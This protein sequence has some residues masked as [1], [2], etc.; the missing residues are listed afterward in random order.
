MDK[1][2]ITQDG[3]ELLAKMT[4]GETTAEFTKFCTSSA[5]YAEAELSNLTGLKDTCQTSEVTNVTI[6]E[7]HTVVLT[8]AI[9]NESLQEGYY[10]TA[11]GLFAQGAGEEEILY[12]VCK[13]TSPAYMPE[14]SGT[15]SGMSIKFSVKVGNSENLVVNVDNSTAATL[16]DLQELKDEVEAPVF[17]DYE[18]TEDPTLPEMETALG[19]IKS[20]TKLSKLMQYI[21]A[22]LMI[23]DK[24]EVDM[25]PYDQAIVELMD[26]DEELNEDISELQGQI[27][28]FESTKSDI[29]SSGLGQAIGL[30]AS[31]TW[32]QLVE[33]IKS[34]VNRGAI[35]Q[36]LNCG[37]SYTIPA[38]YHNGSGQVTANSLTSQTDATAGAGQILSGYT[39]WVKGSKITGT[40]ANKGAVSQALNCGGSYTIPAGYHNGSG[41]V[42]ANSLASQTDA[43][44]AAGQILSGYTAWVKG[45]KITGSMANKGNLN[46]SGSNT[47]YS[48]PAG[49]YSGGTLDS[50]PSYNA[51]VAAG[52]VTGWASKTVTATSSGSDLSVTRYNGKQDSTGSST[53]PYVQFNTGVSKVMA[54]RV[55]IEN[56]VITWHAGMP[57]RAIHFDGN[58]SGTGGYEMG[59]IGSGNWWVNGTNARLPLAATGQSGYRN[60]SAKITI[61][62]L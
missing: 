54:I 16:G 20:G 23:L 11:I 50:R 57:S 10:I 49:Y 25:S 3:Q 46:W 26:K 33:K 36:A 48:V 45:S 30:T 27:S 38:G 43:T 47:T 14:M 61:W 59:D 41:K 15:L 7:D 58:Q 62:Y 24:R 55:L 6:K 2:I 39:A 60:K 22:A 8:G 18:A 12:A 34:I 40:M 13:L 4:A 5:E 19:Q 28:S 51:G 53:S 1:I 17:E 56:A 44:A 35:S 31:S 42:T 37:G 21:K 52:K 29:V 9:D 32:A